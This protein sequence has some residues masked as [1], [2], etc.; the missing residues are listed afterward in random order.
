MIDFRHKAFRL[1]WRCAAVLATIGCAMSGWGQSTAFTYQGRLNDGGAPANGT[2]DFQFRIWNALVEGINVTGPLTAAPVPVTNGLFTVTLDAGAAAFNGA[3]RWLEIGVRTNGSASAHTV[4]APRQ[5][6]TSVPYALRA[7]TTDASGVTTGTLPDSVL[8]ENVARLADFLALSNA[9]VAQ[10]TAVSNNVLT[11]LPAGVTVASADPNDEALVGQG[12]RNILTAAAPPWTEGS[13][14]TQPTARY[15]HSTIWT[16]QELIVWG[17]NLSASIYSASGGRYQPGTDQWTTVSSIDAPEAR[18]EHTAVWNGQEMIIWGG[19]GDGYLDSG[20]RYEPALQLWHPL[21]TNGAPAARS[22][23]VA[24]WTGSRM[25]IWGGQNGSGLLNDGALY[26]PSS[27]SWATLVLPNAPAAR[28]G[29]TALWAGDRLLVWGGDG[30]SGELNTGAQLTFDGAGEPVS[31]QAISTTNAPSARS[32]HIAVWTGGR[33]IIWGGTDSG[34]LLSDGASYD[35]TN[36]TW[37]TLAATNAP[38]ARTGHSAVWTGTELLVWG[39]EGAGGSLAEGGAYDPIIDKWRALS[40]GGN[41]LAR[42]GASVVWSG[43]EV[44][45]FGG[46]SS[47]TSVA[48]LQRLNPQPTWYFYRRP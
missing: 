2:Y 32:G 6:I 43:T 26:N 27:D 10:I 14:V 46:R 37:A 24:V 11:N 23:H 36:D 21:A 29:A 42:S 4:L 22:R 7:L 28:R 34:T 38:A 9:L 12:L 18:S 35:P 48:A 31:W 45:V 40:N 19:F 1:A 3:D 15:Q 17:G 47:G 44:L 41:P 16:G 20:G 5:Q 33:M 8:S 30:E 25:V 13:T 39:G